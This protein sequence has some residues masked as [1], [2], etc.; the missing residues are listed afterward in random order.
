MSLQPGDLVGLIGPKGPELGLVESLNGSRA[1]LLVGWEGR[2]QHLPQR[3]L[4][5]LAHH[6]GAEAPATR[7][8]QPP[9]RLVEA[10]LPA[11]RPS[12]RDFGAAWLLLGETSCELEDF[13]ALIATTDT[14]MARA[15]CWLA[16]QDPG[17]PFFRWRHGLVQPRSLRD[18]RQLR[19]ERRLG[20]L[21]EQRQQAW[22]ELLRQRQPIDPAG[23]APAQR[24][25][26]EQLLGFASGV[27][28]TPLPLELRRALQQAHCEAQ[29]GPIRHLLVDLGQWER[30]GLPSLRQTVWERGFEPALL[31]EAERLVAAA[32]Q[33]RP[34]DRDRL[35]LTALRTYSLDDA[36][37][38][39]IDDALS[40]E[41]VGDGRRRLWVHIAD[42][43]RL[44]AADSPLDLE[45]RQRASSLYLAARVVP[46]FPLSLAAGPFSLRQGQRCA[47]W[48]TAIEL[49]SDGAVHSASI[50]RSWVRP[51]YRLTYADG[52][53]LIELAP[54]QEAD[55]AELHGLL[56]LRRGWRER[57]GALSMEQP[58]GRIRCRDERA[59]LEVTELSA[60]R[61]LVAE[62]MILNG[63]VVA[64]YGVRHGLALPY[65]S[66][67]ASELPPASELNAL[68]AGPVR[69]AA[70]RRCLSRGSSGVRPAPH[71]SLGLGAYV[72]A[73]SPI[74]RYAD[75][76]VQRQLAAL[77]DEG[78]TPLD[79][80]ALAELLEGLDPVVREGIQIS[81]EDQRHWQQVWFEQQRAE[82]W[83]GLFLRWLRP[84]DR[85]GLVHLESLALDQAVLCPETSSPG[86]PLVVRV[87]AVDSLADLLRLE[88]SLAS[89]RGR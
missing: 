38:A 77:A 5:L 32:A 67:P 37:T 24:L 25:Q 31:A 88:A 85:L 60:A 23:L 15:A 83:D 42:P 54:P 51:T 48:S 7:L 50:Q 18:L 61:A 20:R 78:G 79:E 12:A 3:Q 47:A 63:A 13:V 1:A 87:S 10:E 72:Q 80:Q 64:D 29:A 8:G 36:D 39:E 14:P 43:G 55:L 70:L 86:D 46:M 82:C 73:T 66:Q 76:L 58:E 30:H 81:R 6:R 45:A 9:W 28:D 41:T 4:D 84:Q 53:E 40:L 71:F 52:D 17:Q 49:D 59:E 44:I 35:D 26:L 68:P 22:S 62:A 57:Q 16:L 34:G 11:Q 74:R 19:H 33:E 65:R 89:S 69:H 56:L 75:L 2:A 27:S 21:A